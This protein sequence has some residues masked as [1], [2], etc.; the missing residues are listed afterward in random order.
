MSDTISFKEYIDNAVSWL[1]LYVERVFDEKQKALELAFSAQQ[2]ALELATRALELRLEKLNELR[3]EV[4]QD[5]GNYVTKDK[6]ES[7]M[8]LLLSKIEDL[9]TNQTL[10]TGRGSGLSL[11][12][13]VALS[14][15][16]VIGTIAFVIDIIIKLKP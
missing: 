16:G 13:G 6:H 5:R 12:W 15:I 4:T 8:G 1:K 11:A 14:L 9:K 10:N 7:D 3:Q 2:K